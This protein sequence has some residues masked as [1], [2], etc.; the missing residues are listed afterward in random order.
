MIINNFNLIRAIF[1][2][3]KADSPLIVNANAVLT[4]SIARQLL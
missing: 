2:P 4:Q 3:G 1:F